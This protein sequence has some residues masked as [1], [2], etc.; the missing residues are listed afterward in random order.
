MAKRVK[1]KDPNEPVIHVRYKGVWDMQDLY[2]AMADWFRRRK[3]KFYE[4]I[5]KHKHPSPFGVERQYTW[6]AERKETD[7]IM[8]RYNIYMHI[9]DAH[10]VEVVTP[11]GKKNIFTRG[12]IWI[13]LRIGV[14]S[15]YEGR[16]NE[17]LF[18][19]HLKNFYNAYVL[20]KSFTEGWGPKNRYEVY[21]LAAMI[22]ERL[23]MEADEYEHRYFVGVHKKF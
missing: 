5:Y 20:R 19:S 7:Y 3:Y 1:W 4:Y 6:V 13:E 18:Y 15:D 11:D 16:W 2:E 8:I 21:G 9:Y 23:K 22:K 14:V 12:R 17:K 10:D